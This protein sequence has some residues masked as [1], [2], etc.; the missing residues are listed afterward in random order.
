M[1][2]FVFVTWKLI[3]IV[4]RRETMSTVQTGGKTHLPFPR[5]PHNVGFVDYGDETVLARIY[6]PTKQSCTDKLELW[7]LWAEDEYLSGLLTFIKAMSH[8]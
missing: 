6:Y 4:F 7:P 8:R 5:G 1:I 3:Y 2:S